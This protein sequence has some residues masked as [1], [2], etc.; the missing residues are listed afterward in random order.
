MYLRLLRETKTVFVLDRKSSAEF[1]TGPPP[2]QR[3]PQL[4]LGTCSDQS[5]LM[6]PV[7]VFVII[8]LAHSCFLGQVSAGGLLAHLFT[9][10]LI[11]VFPQRLRSC[12]HQQRWLSLCGLTNTSTFHRIFLNGWS[13]G[14]GRGQAFAFSD[15]LIVPPVFSLLSGGKCDKVALSLPLP[16][17]VFAASRLFS[18]CWG[19][20]VSVCTGRLFYTR[21][22]EGQIQ[23]KKSMRK[24][25]CRL[26]LYFC[27]P[28]SS[29][30]NRD[31]AG[32]KWEDH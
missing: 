23:K 13:R 7:T 28:G 21:L 29:E 3:A 10:C 32:P 4:L 8:A 26:K 14:C 9:L 17:T 30:R 15:P 12:I 19:W 18:S 16:L 2:W 5:H 24:Q 6:T 11:Y 1:R 31:I 27:Q 25:L 22:Q 20:G